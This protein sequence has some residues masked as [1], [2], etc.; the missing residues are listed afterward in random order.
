[1]CQHAIL[2]IMV[3]MLKENVFRG[4]RL[5]KIRLKLN[6]TQA[7]LGTLIQVAQT[8][9]TLY[10]TSPSDKGNDPSAR[11]LLRIATKLNVTTD[12]LLGKGDDDDFNA[13]P[14]TSTSESRLLNAYR[15]RDIKTLLSIVSDL[16]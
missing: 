7:E 16:I 5:R 1:M 8:Q 3:S 12:W 9:I 15:T 13:T 2:S 14:I 10:E 4:D 6:L 11:V